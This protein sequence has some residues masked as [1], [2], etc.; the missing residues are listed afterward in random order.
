[1]YFCYYL[2]QTPICHRREKTYSLQ[3]CQLKLQEKIRLYSIHQCRKAQLR[4]MEVH[5]KLAVS[6]PKRCKVRRHLHVISLTDFIVLDLFTL[7]CGS[8]SNS[9][10][11]G[12]IRNKKKKSSWNYS[13]IPVPCMFKDG[14]FESIVGKKKKIGKTII[15]NVKQW[16]KQ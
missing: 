7:Q 3:V 12:I 15:S 14:Y 10:L 6:F 9:Y 5:Y 4:R 16:Y 2:W 8:L 1:M 11:L 13:L